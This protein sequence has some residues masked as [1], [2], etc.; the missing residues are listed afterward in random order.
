LEASSRPFE[1]R[2]VA[3]AS[4]AAISRHTGWRHVAVALPEEDGYWRF[5]GVLDS[6]PE[7]RVPLANGVVGRAFR[8]G[9]TQVVENVEAD[10]D[11]VPSSSLV[12]SELAVPLRFG[13]SILGVLNLESDVAAAFGPRVVRVAESVADPIALGLENARL[14]RAIASESARLAASLESNRELEKLRDDLTRTMVHDLRSPLTAILGAVE[15]VETSPGLSPEN[16]RMLEIANVNAQRQLRLINSILDVSRLE[17][18]AL[19]LER[20]RVGLRDLI[21]EVV[22]LL[23]PRALADGIELVDD[24]SEKLPDALVDRELLDRVLENLV[25]NAIKFTPPGG[26]VRVVGSRLDGRALQVTVSDT[27]S[28]VPE[29]MKPRL[30]QKFAAGPQKAR[31]T[32]LGLAFCRLAVEAHGGRVWLESSSASGASFAFTLPLA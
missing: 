24:V 31:G 17:S 23:R 26:T 12:R 2:E 18:G 10:P 7:S 11:Y 32:G 1:A 25:V 28:G 22:H 21:V 27:G 30:F 20:S 8:T 16:L 14:Y 15:M 19:P 5:S 3:E 29:E 13:E 6:P 9:R 4:A